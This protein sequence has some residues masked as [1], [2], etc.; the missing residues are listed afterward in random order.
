MKASPADYSSDDIGKSHGKAGSLFTA[1]LNIDLELG[2][3]GY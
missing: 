1:E 3:R 2:G